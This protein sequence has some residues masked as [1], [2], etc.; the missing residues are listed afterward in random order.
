MARAFGIA[1]HLLLASLAIVLSCGGTQLP[2]EEARFVV[3]M[4]AKNAFEVMTLAY[5]YEAVQLYQDHCTD[6]PCVSEIDCEAVTACSALVEQ[7]KRWKPSFDLYDKLAATVETGD[8]KEAHKLYC[9]LVT[10]TPAPLP[11]EVCK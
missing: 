7:R 3:H 4:S 9:A 11:S 5:R 10:I 1:S 2:V 6:Y 8:V